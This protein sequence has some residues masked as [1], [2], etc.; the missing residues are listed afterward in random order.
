MSSGS[1]LDA[2]AG[3]AE[4]SLELYRELLQVPSVWGDARELRRAADLLG[5]A[6]RD[7]GLDVQLPDSGTPEMPMLLARLPGRAGGPTLLLA[8]HMEVYPPSQSWTLDPWGATVRDGRV[9]GQGSADM[10]GGTAAM[11]AA[12]AVLGRAG[13]ELPGD[14]VVL[15]VP[16]HFEGGEGT[17]KAL[18]DGLRVDAAI[19]CEPTDLAVVTGQRGI[20][21]LDITVR[22]RAA[23][24]TALRIGVNAIDRAA[25][26]VAALGEMTP[27]D[28]G[29]APVEAEAM[30]NVAMID[31][32]LV[33]NIVPER[34]RVTVDIRFPPEQTA[35]D[36]LR[37]VR[38]A[39]ASANADEV[40]FPTKIEPEAT[41]IRNP[42]SSLRLPDDHPLVGWTA[43]MHVAATGRPVRLGFHPAWPDTPIINEAG[44]PAVT[45][46]PG[47]MECYWD[48][49]S[50]LV[51]DYLAAVRTYCLAAATGWQPG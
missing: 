20:L 26:I 9:Y 8:G 46:G 28:A 24:T 4:R 29:G 25:R 32:G 14:L 34:C 31:G 11:C 43:E 10:K 1:V 6:L 41:C 12:A 19:V 39:V 15:A 2:A 17:R 33:H 27:H 45:Y 40:D 30:V 38:H 50:V 7:A 47:S 42:R 13:A 21:Y 18:R 5:S 35:A 49:E 37:D 48:D 22:G 36:V 3:D 23:H 16:N 51:D 44:I